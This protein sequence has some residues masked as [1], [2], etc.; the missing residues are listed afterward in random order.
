MAKRV[1]IEPEELSLG[2]ERGDDLSGDLDLSTDPAWL[3]FLEAG[4]NTGIDPLS[5]EGL[6]IQA[7]YVNQVGDHPLDVLKT[8]V[9]NP[10]V[11]PSDRISAAKALLEYG[12]RKVPAQFDIKATGMALT[13][14]ASML[15][16]LSD[17][18]LSALEKLLAKAQS[19]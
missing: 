10:W 13:V 8:L 14:D 17:K 11:K 16:K 4:G 18:E 1:R 3:Q 15:S 7:A 2:A 5:D 6:R 9:K 19:A 12:A